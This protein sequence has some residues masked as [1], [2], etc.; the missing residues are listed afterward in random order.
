MSTGVMTKRGQEQAGLG[1]QQQRL[2]SR[3]VPNSNSLSEPSGARGP[4]VTLH[5]Q[6]EPQTVGSWRQLR[7]HLVTMD[8]EKGAPKNVPAHSPS[9]SQG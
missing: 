1:Q 3:D 2:C 6:L 7:T 9:T 8:M 5:V 4:W